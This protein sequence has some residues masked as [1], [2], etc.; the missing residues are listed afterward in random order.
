M[1]PTMETSLNSLIYSN[2]AL[3]LLM[4]KLFLKHAQV[5]SHG[6]PVEYAGLGE[7]NHQLAPH[8]PTAPT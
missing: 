6:F 3:N 4:Y 8:W 7:F 2:F 5:F 1:T